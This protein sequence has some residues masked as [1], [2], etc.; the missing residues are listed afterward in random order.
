[1]P[2]I[3]VVE[4]EDQGKTFPVLFIS[5]EEESVVIVSKQFAD[6]GGKQV[7]RIGEIYCRQNTQSAV[8]GND[9][10]LRKII[11]RVVDQKLIRQSGIRDAVIKNVLSAVTKEQEASPL[12]NQSIDWRQMAKERIGLDQTSPSFLVELSPVGHSTLNPNNLMRAQGL[13]LQ[14][15]AESYPLLGIYNQLC[16]IFPVADGFVAFSKFGNQDNPWLAASAFNKNGTMTTQFGLIE[17]ALY[18]KTD[19]ILY[20]TSVRRFVLIW[21]HAFKYLE[22]LKSQEQWKIEIS[23]IGLKNR[24]LTFDGFQMPDAKQKICI[25]TKFSDTRNFSVVDNNMGDEIVGTCEKFFRLFGVS[26]GSDIGTQIE[27]YLRSTKVQDASI[28]FPRN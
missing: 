4:I 24:I 10:V 17:D 28:F 9:A 26:T 22:I 11:D 2:T 23:V 3:Q 27:K 19:T 21:M 5:K 6:D 1:V 25:E 15:Q 20:S 16:D 7:V 8:V 12:P 18:G 13:D 14:T